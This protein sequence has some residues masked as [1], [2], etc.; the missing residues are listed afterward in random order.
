MR[1]APDID[2]DGVVTPSPL[3]SGWGRARIAMCLAVCVL[4]QDVGISSTITCKPVLVTNLGALNVFQA[5][6]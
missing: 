4:T 6:F 3:G 2:R 1:L 5:I